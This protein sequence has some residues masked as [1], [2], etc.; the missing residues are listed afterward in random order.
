MKP[1]LE[2]LE[3]RITPTSVCEANATYQAEWAYVNNLI[4]Q[5]AVTLTA[6]QSGNW[7]NPATWGGRLPTF[8]DLVYIPNG[9]TV[10]V[11]NTS[12]TALA[13][14]NNGLLIL[15]AAKTGSSS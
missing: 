7:S 9:D 12:A 5:S 13:I 2:A 8:N 15:H 4:P 10:N 1:E 6:V 3:D 14:L 11:D